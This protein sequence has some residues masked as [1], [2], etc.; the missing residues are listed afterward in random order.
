MMIDA[1]RYDYEDEKDK[2][3]VNLEDLSQNEID[4]FFNN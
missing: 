3:K 2:G 1:A 4:S